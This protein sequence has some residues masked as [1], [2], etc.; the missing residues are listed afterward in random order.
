MDLTRKHTPGVEDA[1]LHNVS[2]R[3]SVQIGCL[4]SERICLS[5]EEVGEERAYG[6]A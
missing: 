5:G 2:S 6:I 3:V 1:D 4:Q